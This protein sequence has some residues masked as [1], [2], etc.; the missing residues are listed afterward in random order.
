MLDANNKPVYYGAV[1]RLGEVDRY[2]LFMSRLMNKDYEMKTEDLSKLYSLLP[3]DVQKEINLSADS[4]SE[5]P[6]VS[7]KNYTGLVAGAVTIVFVIA[8]VIGY[9][10]IKKRKK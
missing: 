9:S 8:F 10:V 3:A 7:K 4:P 1:S 6:A 5:L 2:G